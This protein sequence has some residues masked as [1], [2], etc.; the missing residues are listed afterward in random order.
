MISTKILLHK[1]SSHGNLLG[2]KSEL[3][4]LAHTSAIVTT[5]TWYHAIVDD[6][7]PDPHDSAEHKEKEA[8]PDKF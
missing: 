5:F 3:R 6:I 1:T 7:W 4:Y 8:P 2:E